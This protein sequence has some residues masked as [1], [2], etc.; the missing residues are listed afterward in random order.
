MYLSIHNHVS[1]YTQLCYIFSSSLHICI[2]PYSLV[3]TT[4]TTE[5]GQPDEEVR[6]DGPRGAQPH[7]DHADGESSRRWG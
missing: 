4:T 7:E 6:D 1:I 3:T 5:H 2:V